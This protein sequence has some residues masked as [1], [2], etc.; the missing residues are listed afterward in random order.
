MADRYIDYASP[1]SS[2]QFLDMSDVL[3]L[4]RRGIE[5][6]LDMG[7]GNQNYMTRRHDAAMFADPRIRASHGASRSKQRQ[8]QRARDK[9]QFGPSILDSPEFSQDQ[10]AA[11]LSLQDE[12]DAAVQPD[13][14]QRSRTAGPP[15]AYFRGIR[16][17]PPGTAQDQA[18]ASLA[19]RDTIDA[20]IARQQAER[21]GLRG[22]SGPPMSAMGRQEL[23]PELQQDAATVAAYDAQQPPPADAAPYPVDPRLSPPNNVV[24]EQG[25]PLDFLQAGVGA[26]G[27]AAIDYLKP[28]GPYGG[29]GYGGG[30]PA[31]QAPYPVDPRLSPPT[32]DAPGFA[33]WAGAGLKAVGNAAIDAF[34]PQGPYGGGAYSQSPK[35]DPGLASAL[36]PFKP[37]GPY[38]GGGY[39]GTVEPP[40]PPEVNPRRPEAATPGYNPP[41]ADASLPPKDGGGVDITSLL[42]GGDSSPEADM[43]YINKLYGNFDT[44]NP[45]QDIADANAARE[46]ERTAALAQLAL[47]SGILRGSGKSWEG[48]GVGFGSA[49]GAFDKGFA[50]YQ[51]ALQDSADRYSKQLD[52]QRAFEL[53]KR[54]S[55]VDMWTAR[56]ADQRELMKFA[57][58]SQ[59]DT[60]KE[61]MAAGRELTKQSL[62]H[63][64]DQ[65]AKEFAYKFP[66]GADYTGEDKAG[67][68]SVTEF[69]ERR[70]DALSIGH[71]IPYSG[72][73]VSDK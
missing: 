58:E 24:T 67:G 40:L 37:Q 47:A 26:A 73:N 62:D 31:P 45:K 15:Q 20:D 70:Q 11:S 72:G 38:G 4:G 9:G 30:R 3:S 2:D 57:L 8:L 41:P 44:A 18:A 63:L 53:A 28:Q 49:A 60:N 14:S 71:Y 65:Y 32:P 34:K 69:Q 27:K 50:R 21:A 54:G 43:D 39:G 6:L 48:L 61:K 25:S 13:L 29:G 66:T 22:Q 12:A 42:G 59:R 35:Q 33:D 1:A 64:S 51:N 52:S 7:L 23:T 36:D 16:A 55:A 5:T 46:G 10:A 56:H 17:L 68:E 19:N